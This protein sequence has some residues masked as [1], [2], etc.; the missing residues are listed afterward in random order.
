M[1]STQDML[2]VL[3]R[4]NS[5]EEGREYVHHRPVGRKCNGG[6]FFYKK[7]EHIEAE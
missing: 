7:V 2:Q 1:V 3:R 6:C 4:E 5:R